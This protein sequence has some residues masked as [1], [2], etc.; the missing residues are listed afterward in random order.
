[1]AGKQRPLSSEPSL[2]LGV[3]STVFT[4]STRLTPG[5]LLLH[6]GGGGGGVEGEAHVVL[7][8]NGNCW[9]EVGNVNLQSVFGAGSG[10]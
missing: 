7:I 3:E 8:Y 1:M 2:G 6:Q 4:T 5:P 10:G 9:Y